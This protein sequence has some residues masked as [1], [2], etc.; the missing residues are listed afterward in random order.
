MAPVI[1]DDYGDWKG[2]GGRT[3]DLSEIAHIM[4]GK[5][6]RAFEI[7]S[8]FFSGGNRVFLHFSPF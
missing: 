1:G 7:G 5:P 6:Q 8:F 2:R 4:R 3:G